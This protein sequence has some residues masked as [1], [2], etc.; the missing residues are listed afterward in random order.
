MLPSNPTGQL[1]GH[2]PKRGY[3]EKDI[4]RGDDNRYHQKKKAKVIRTHLQNG[5]H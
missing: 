4:E 1:A 5:R 3:Q 2:D